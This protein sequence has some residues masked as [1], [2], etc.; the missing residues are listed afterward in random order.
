MLSPKN[1]PVRSQLRWVHVQMYPLCT[2]PETKV[3]FWT[4]VVTHLKD[5]LTLT[6]ANPQDP[7]EG[8]VWPRALA[9]PKS[10]WKCTTTTGVGWSAPQS[11][12]SC[13]G[14]KSFSAWTLSSSPQVLRFLLTLEQS[15][16]WPAPPVH[17]H[18]LKSSSAV[19]FRVLCGTTWWHLLVV[20]ISPREA[21]ELALCTWLLAVS[22]RVTSYSLNWH[23][24]Q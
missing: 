19:H 17:C 5:Y 18:T 14:L 1:L 9:S 7:F 8:L 4:P 21:S 10:A 16:A 24:V 6:P 12:T 23:I 22:S 15:R 3:G 2:S 20:D 11:W 13:R